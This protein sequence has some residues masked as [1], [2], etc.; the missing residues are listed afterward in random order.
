MKILQLIPNLSSGGAERFVVDLSNELGK[1]HDVCLITSFS[2]D[3]RNAF[4]LQELSSNVRSYSLNKKIGFDIQFLFRLYKSI[5]REKPDIVHTHLDTFAYFA[6]IKWLFPNIKFIHT[7]HSE[8]QY[9]AGGKIRTGLKKLF[10]RK[11]WCKAV[12]ISKK[13]EISFHDYYGDAVQ[14]NL[15]YN[16][17]SMDIKTAKDNHLIP[18]VEGRY[19]LVSI[20]HISKTKNH[21]LLCS[22][23]NKLTQSGAPIE[24]YMFGRYVDD[25]IVSKIKAINNPHI[26]LLGEIDNPR[27][28]LENADAFCMSS[29]Y[30]GLPISLIEALSCGLIPICTA[31]GGIVD[32]VVDGE[33]GFLSN[34]LE[35]DTYAKTIARFLAMSDTEFT[36]MT[37]RCRKLGQKYSIE[38]CA[39]QYEDL[40]NE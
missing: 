22:A 17:R 30:E 26:H 33:T 10:F 27:Q 34:D 21:L 31:V 40:F 1:K 32:L 38:Q 15:I 39:K 3:D 11:G 24:L 23:V 25:V 18:R 35:V 20:G 9:E 7:V 5:K 8:A 16:G 13:S 28:Y 37:N 29:L 36:D 6:I 14:S 19:N 12:T 4:Y 2:L